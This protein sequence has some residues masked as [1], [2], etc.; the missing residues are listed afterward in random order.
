MGEN[1]QTGSHGTYNHRH[2]HTHLHTDANMQ[3]LSAGFQNKG[4]NHHYT[5]T[6]AAH[7]WA[8]GL[9]YLRDSSKRHAEALAQ[10]FTAAGMATKVKWSEAVCARVS[11]E[12][13]TLPEQTG[14]GGNHKEDRIEEGWQC[15][16]RP[17]SSHDSND[18]QHTVFERS[19]RV[20]SDVTADSDTTPPPRDPAQGRS[21]T[22]GTDG[23][24]EHLS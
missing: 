21:G 4:I 1:T 9:L 6:N 10:T 8:G 24:T 11:R 13:A 20:P 14:R 23:R 12:R 19:C 2:T 3:Q 16:T 15:L 22:C 5:H 7:G 17:T 18:V